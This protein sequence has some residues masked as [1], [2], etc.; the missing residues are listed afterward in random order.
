M[1]PLLIMSLVV[2]I[3]VFGGH[4]FLWSTLVKF[5]AIE[6]L[7]WR[8]GLL[9]VIIVLLLILAA[10]LWLKLPNNNFWTNFHVGAFWWIGILANLLIFSTLTWI[11]WFSASRLNCPVNSPILISVMLGL[12]L[13][14]SIIGLINAAH[15]A[16]VNLD[17]SLPNLPEAWKGKKIVQLSDMH[18]GAINNDDYLQKITNIVNGL[19][20]DLIVYTGDL[21]DGTGGA[22]PNFASIINQMKATSGSYF[23][24]G[25]HET[26]F[27]MDEVNKLL[28]ETNLK[29]LRDQKVDLNGLQLV[30]LDGWNF[31][32]RS[33]LAQVFTK[34]NLDKNKPSILLYH[35]PANVPE[36][37]A[38]GINLW[39]AGHTHRGQL[40]PFNWL[41]TLIYK[42]YGHGLFQDKNFITYVSAGV[43]TWGPPMRTSGRPEIVVVNLK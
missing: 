27:G 4:L 26:Y 42:G 34:I 30:G 5:Y 2:I 14:I 1:N 28:A 9:A 10:A 22:G 8:Y 20:P 41:V 12:S 17:L 16:I 38:A 19:H 11:I 31:N 24:F 21:F 29:V 36:I 18:Y 35:I 32:G 15:P 23:V 39:L 37:K 33:D 7:Y 6:S 25:N 13:L 3:V 43:G 40:W